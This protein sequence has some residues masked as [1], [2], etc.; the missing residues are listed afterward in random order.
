MNTEEIAKSIA[1]AIAAA[2]PQS[3][4]DGHPYRIG[5][6]YAIRTLTMIQTGKLEAVYQQEL[7]FSNAAW[8]A[9]TGRWTQFCQN[10]NNASEVEPFA[11]PVIVQRSNIIDV[12]EISEFLPVQK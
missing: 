10:A 7:V 1:A 9:D 4:A 3:P 5:A 12:T 8:I 11:N 6:W 2:A